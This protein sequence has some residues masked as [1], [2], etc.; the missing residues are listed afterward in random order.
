MVDEFSN[1]SESALVSDLIEREQKRATDSG[2]LTL[3]TAEP[4]AHYDHYGNR[5]YADLYFE[6]KHEE[7]NSV[8]FE[9]DLYEIKSEH[10]VMQANGAGEIIR[11]FKRMRRYFFQDESREKRG[12]AAYLL[13]FIPTPITLHHVE[14]NKNLYKQIVSEPGNFP[15]SSVL[16]RGPGVKRNQ[17]GLPFTQ[18]YDSVGHNLA[19]SRPGLARRAGVDIQTIHG[20][21]R[22]DR[23]SGCKDITLN[24]L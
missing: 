16:F 7:S 11:Q 23:G 18:W 6:T 20:V 12:P 3:L 5:G 24:D 1:T 9:H 8:Y 19:L 2:N 17:P 13:C 10:A 15:V 4:E 22:D 21:K 14:E